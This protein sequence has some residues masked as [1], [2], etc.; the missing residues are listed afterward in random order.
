MIA[1]YGSTNSLVGMY[2]CEDKCNDAVC[3][4]RYGTVINVDTYRNDYAPN[5]QFSRDFLRT[6]Y[7]EPSHNNDFGIRDSNANDNNRFAK[8]FV[9]GTFDRDENFLLQD[10]IK[11]SS[12]A[13]DIGY[14]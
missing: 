10:P 2:C 1:S 9:D 14:D 3:Y 5:S 11:R 12:D 6:N 13:G 8:N 4:D 7:R